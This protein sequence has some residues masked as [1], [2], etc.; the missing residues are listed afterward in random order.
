MLHASETQHLMYIS[1]SLLLHFYSPFGKVLDVSDTHFHLGLSR[2][3]FLAPI[4]TN[5]V[6]IVS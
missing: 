1:P 5:L 2:R 6:A 3:L 4:E